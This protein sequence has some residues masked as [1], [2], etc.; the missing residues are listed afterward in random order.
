MVDKRENKEFEESS[1]S[2]ETRTKEKEPDFDGKALSDLY[3]H[4]T[5]LIK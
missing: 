1:E 2:Y 3:R 5:K 4:T